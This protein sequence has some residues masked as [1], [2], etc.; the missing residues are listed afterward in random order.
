MAMS[1]VASLVMSVPRD[2]GADAPSRARALH[3]CAANDFGLSAIVSSFNIPYLS[4]KRRELEQR[5]ASV[6]NELQSAIAE[7]DALASKKERKEDVS[8]NAF[9]LFAKAHKTTTRTSRCMRRCN[10]TKAK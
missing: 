3:F 10:E 2:G 5:L 9:T 1:R 8:C 6:N 4:M 7:Q